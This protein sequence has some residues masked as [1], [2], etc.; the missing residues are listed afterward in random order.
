[1]FV[2]NLI[3]VHLPRC[4]P[5]HHCPQRLNGSGS[6]LPARHRAWWEFSP[7]ELQVDD[8]SNQSSRGLPRALVSWHHHHHRLTAV[9][10]SSKRMRKTHRLVVTTHHLH[11]TEQAAFL[12]SE[13]G[14]HNCT[15]GRCCQREC[16]CTTSGPPLR[17]FKFDDKRG[18]SESF[19]FASY[20]TAAHLR[21]AHHHCYA[22]RTVSVAS[23]AWRSGHHPAPIGTWWPHPSW[24]SAYMQINTAQQKWVFKPEDSH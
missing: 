5:Q 23:T 7:V 1:M 16:S 12:V 3:T 10:L 20:G 19:W 11:F 22:G 18:F 8:I 14:H 6:L 21:L 4:R 9:C 17:N 13:A 2:T 24:L 15:Q